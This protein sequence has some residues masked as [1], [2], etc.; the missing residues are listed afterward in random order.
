MA[1]TRGDGWKVVMKIN[2]PPEKQ[3]H[4]GHS[5]LLQGDTA[6][7][8]VASLVGFGASEEQAEFIGLRFIEYAAVG[9]AKQA[10]GQPAQTLEAAP[11]VKRT[12][13]P[14]AQPGSEAAVSDDLASPAVLKAVAKK[15]GKSVE[16]LGAMTKA[17]AKAALKGGK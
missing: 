14:P 6:E 16:E 15:T 17:Q 8:I 12:D 3:Y 4:S 7:E 10:L 2:L 5:L 1:G 13:S 11:E 9:A